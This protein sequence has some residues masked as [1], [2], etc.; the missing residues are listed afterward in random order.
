MFAFLAYS[1]VPLSLL[2]LFLAY[3]YSNDI[4][5]MIKVVS[6]V[7]KAGAN[8][9]TNKSNQEFVISDDNNY[10]TITLSD[11]HF[12][13][14][15]SRSYVAKML[16]LIFEVENYDGTTRNI[17]HSPGIPYLV[18]PINLGVKSI[19]VTNMDSGD[20]VHYYEDEFPNY[21]EKAL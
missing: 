8:M 6:I 10:A 3:R 4:I 17:T 18:S 21:G 2:S 7:W 9:S 15:Y 11:K 12:I 16:S 19:I 14:P 20:V 1:L 5:K 13:M